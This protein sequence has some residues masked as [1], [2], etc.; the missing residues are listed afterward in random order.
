MSTTLKDRVTSLAAVA[1]SG[2]AQALSTVAKVAGA[3]ASTLRPDGQ[4]GRTDRADGAPP[5]PRH[6][7]TGARVAETF[8][9]RGTVKE[10][11]QVAVGEVDHVA[12]APSHIAEVADGTVADVVAAIPDLSTDELRLLIQHETSHKNRKGVLDA[13]EE[14]LT[15]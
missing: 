6:S 7:D 14:A 1:L 11:T 4:T 13:V 15:P 10:R 3:A 8:L 2:T 9:Q 12:A 5:R